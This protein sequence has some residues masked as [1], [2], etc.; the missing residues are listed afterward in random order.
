EVGELVVRGAT[1]MRGYWEKPEATAKRLKPGPLP[2]EMMLY[3][4]DF[5]KQD[6]DGYIYFA[7][8]MDDISKS[9]GEEVDPEEVENA[10]VAID[11]VKEAAVIGVPD[12]ILGSAIKAFV[13][14]E[15]GADLVE[16]QIQNECR[17]RLENFMVPKFVVIVED[18]PKTTTGKIKKTGLS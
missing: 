14:L 5:C 4:G 1:V 10:L 3:S 16:K 17:A 11:G 12:D 8:R 6:E 13:V 9:P 2:G 18:L 15:Q 7:G